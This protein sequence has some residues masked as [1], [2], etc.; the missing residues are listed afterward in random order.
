M[1]KLKIMVSTSFGVEAIVKKELRKLNYEVERVKNGRIEFSGEAADLARVNLE[2]R[3][4]ERVYLKLGEFSATDFDTLYD[5]VN[6]IAWADYIPY[7]GEFPVTGKS[8]KSE[9]HNVPACQSIIKKA[10]VDKLQAKHGAGRLPES[11][12]KYPITFMINKDRVII[13]LD[14]SGTGLHRRGYRQEAGKAPIKETIA[15]AMVYLSKWN[16]DRILVDPFCGSGTILIEAALMAKKIAPGINRDFVSENWSFLPE[17][18]YAEARAESREREWDSAEP[19][20]LA[21]YDQDKNAVKQA[22]YNSRRAGVEDL[23]HFQQQEIADFS[24]NRQY[25]YIITNPPYGE[26]MAEDKVVELYKMMGEKFLP[27]STWSF[28]ILSAHP[29]FEQHFGK[30]ASKRR[31]LYNGGL[32]CQFYQYY[33]PWPPSDRS[34]D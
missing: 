3:A 17:N 7:Q 28:Y 20:L 15:A 18:L 16:R 2:L 8:S 27:L 23:I 5:E 13:A 22:I 10:V 31:K 26:R 12:S 19:R 30:K 1:S 21:G 24:T 32:E 4:A 29:E 11:G 6:K 33:G 9:L 25:G 34:D 14:S